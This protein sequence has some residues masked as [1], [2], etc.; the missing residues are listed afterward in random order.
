MNI[1]ITAAKRNPNQK[2]PFNFDFEADKSLLSNKLSKFNKKSNFYGSYFFNGD[3]IVVEGKINYSLTYPCDRC[4]KPVEYNDVIEF[5]EIFYKD[6]TESQ[7]YIYSGDVLD[8]TKAVS[9]YIMLNI[10]NRLVCDEKCKGL[11]PVCGKNLNDGKCN[12]KITESENPFSILKKTIS[13][14]K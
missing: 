8:L 7:D 2:F 13:F 4:L 9:D 5:Y 6:K 10:P 14:K 12:C 3:N 1:D 11:C